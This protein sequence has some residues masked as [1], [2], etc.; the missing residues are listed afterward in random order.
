MY[1]R[2]ITKFHFFP[3]SRRSNGADILSFLIELPYLIK[4]GT[5]NKDLAKGSNFISYASF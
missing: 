1:F 5:E 3:R 2:L 4:Q